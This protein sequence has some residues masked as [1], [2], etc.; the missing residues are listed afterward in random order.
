MEGKICR[1]NKIGKEQVMA[2]LAVPFRSPELATD[3]EALKKRQKWK[4]FHCKNGLMKKFHCK[5][6]HLK[7]SHVEKIPIG[8]KSCW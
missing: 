6:S 8:K 2:I 5:K 7:E 1:K 3:K 4:K